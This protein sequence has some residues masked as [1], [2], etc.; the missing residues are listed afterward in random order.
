MAT[1]IKVTAYSL[2]GNSN[3][4]PKDIVLP[5]NGFS[6]IAKNDNI[7]GTATYS[8]VQLLATGQQFQVVE[9]PAA[10]AALANTADS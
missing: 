2:G 10:L 3:G 8:V 9:T 1:V 4:F 5:G 7:G 6:A